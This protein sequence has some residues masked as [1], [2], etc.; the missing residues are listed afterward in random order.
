MLSICSANFTTYHCFLTSM[1]KQ[2]DETIFFK[3]TKREPVWFVCPSTS[4]MSIITI[5]RFRVWNKIILN[6]KW[7]F[8]YLISAACV[9]IITLVWTHFKHLIELN[10]IG[11]THDRITNY[12]WKL[13]VFQ[14]PTLLI[15]YELCS[16]F[17][18]TVVVIETNTFVIF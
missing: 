13:F 11:M 2:R 5:I 7:K 4:Q 12:A 15:L 14:I 9:L 8:N 17:N 18:C 16:G 3:R 6:P 10:I 1:S